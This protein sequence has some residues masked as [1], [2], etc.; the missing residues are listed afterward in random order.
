MDTSAKSRITYGSYLGLDRILGSQEP[1]AP[2]ELGATVHAAE[3][4]FIVVH[5]S[6]ELWFRQELL[7]LSRAT[8]ALGFNEL[9][10][11]LA[12][13]HLQRIAAIQRLLC[14]Q[15]VLFDHLSPRSFLAFRPYLGSASGAD[16]EQW[17]KVEQALG[18]GGRPSALYDAFLAAVERAG[19]TLDKVYREPSRAG[20]FYRLAEALVDISETFW[21]LTAA[22]VR[23]AERAIGDR[24]GTGGTGGVSYLEQALRYKAFPEL[25]GVRSRL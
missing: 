21:L 23:V 19:L 20:V 8:V 5:Q 18:L 15:M 1:R 9:D 24:P 6:F 22:H 17:H 7:D 16:S 10:P 2:A 14:Q 13:E 25:W 4:F 12:L 3:H 11:E